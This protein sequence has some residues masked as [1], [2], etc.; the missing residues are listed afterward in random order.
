MPQRAVTA[1]DERSQPRRS[2]THLRR[3]VFHQPRLPQGGLVGPGRRLVWAGTSGRPTRCSISVVVMASSSMPS[4]AARNTRWISTRTRRGSSGGDVT[5]LRAGL[6]GALA[7]SGR[8][9]RR[10]LHEQLLRASAGQSGA[11]SDAGRDSPLPASGRPPR[12]DGAEHQVPAGRVLGFLGSLR[13]PHRSLAQG[14][15]RDTRIHRDVC[16][17]RFLPY[18][19]ASGTALSRRA[20]LRAYLKFPFVWRIFGRQFLVV[21]A[22][23]EV[24]LG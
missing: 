2:P 4:G 3:A 20:L 5:F 15:A 9:A 14:S 23:R 16:L 7:A 11:R 19:M 12:R 13:A 8:L 1:T 21:G 17:G 24:T 22:R 6:L 10:G 18:T